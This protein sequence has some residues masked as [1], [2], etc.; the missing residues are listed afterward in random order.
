MQDTH[1]N[2]W[3][4]TTQTL[5]LQS[6]RLTP[7]EVLD[8]I[9]PAAESWTGKSLLPTYVTDIR[10]YGDGTIVAPQV[11]RLPLVITTMIVVAED[12]REPWPVELIG[13]DGVAV[14]VTVEPGEMIMYE[15]HSVIHGRPY[16]LTGE[17]SA[18]LLVHFEPFGHTHAHQMEQATRSAAGEKV[19]VKSLYEKAKEA[20]K[21]NKETIVAD[22]SM[23]GY[24]DRKS[25]E[26]TWWSQQYVFYQ[27]RNHGVSPP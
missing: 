2:H 7:D 16:A 11:D 14:N 13:H 9:R 27:E 10:F 3:D 1:I 20:A 17:G 25:E 23:P 19:S 8:G 21:N 24:I 18:S 26:P 5:S 12:V 22:S 15:G 6:D 4:G